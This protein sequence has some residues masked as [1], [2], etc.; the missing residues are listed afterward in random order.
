MIK[1]T[2]GRKYKL[3]LNMALMPRYQ[4]IVKRLLISNLSGDTPPNDNLFRFIHFKDFRILNNLVTANDFLFTSLSSKYFYLN[5]F[6]R[7]EKKY[8]NRR[9]TL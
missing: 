3:W 9:K 4:E 1:E 5:C 7:K 8:R 2:D 6:K